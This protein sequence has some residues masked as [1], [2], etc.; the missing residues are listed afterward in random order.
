MGD[1]TPLELHLIGFEKNMITAVKSIKEYKSTVR[2]LTNLKAWRYKK[3]KKTEAK[4]KINNEISKIQNEKAKANTTKI[5][6]DEG[7]KNV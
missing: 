5:D 2:H 4:K 1:T 3:S 6:V 7:E